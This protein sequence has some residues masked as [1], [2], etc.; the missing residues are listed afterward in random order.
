MKFKKGDIVECIDAEQAE[1]IT[2][3]RAYEV[4]D[5]GG[6]M[7]VVVDN[8]N[9]ASTY[10][11]PR[12]ELAAKPVF[13]PGD[14]VRYVGGT[15]YMDLTQNKI[16]AVLS[17]LEGR[18]NVV[19]DVGDEYPYRA[20]CFE[21][22]AQAGQPAFKPG[23]FV[24]CVDA[25]HP[26]DITEG[27]VYHVL[28]C[29]DNFVRIV[30]DA[31]DKGMFYSSRFELAA[32]PVF[33]RGD[34]VRCTDSKQ[35]EDITEGR[36]YE[37]VRDSS[38]HA[39]VVF[40][41]DDTGEENAFRRWRFRAVS[42]PTFKPGDWVRCTHRRGSLDITEGTVYH[43]LE[44]EPKF[45]RIVDDAGDKD[46]YYSDRFELI[47]NRMEEFKK[48]CEP[49]MNWMLKNCNPHTSAIV[50]S[51]NAELMEGVMVCKNEE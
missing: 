40:I 26:S 32:K 33:K 6:G 16:Y 25:E 36:A 9:V 22:A 2:E 19:D 7:V 34:W 27:N 13:E 20:S 28:E 44:C 30:D 41:V 35:A 8:V 31:G 46:M 37:V 47:D 5:Y 23:D 18:I 11:A 49:L 10:R 43:V 38:E 48:A 14:R 24:R 50:N 45:V 1:D 4:L 29:G 42:P 3:G 21:L 12:F 51:L 15:A 39:K 17:Q